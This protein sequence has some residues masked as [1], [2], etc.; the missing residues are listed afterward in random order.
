[1]GLV[2][3]PLVLLLFGFDCP[4]PYLTINELQGTNT[5]SPRVLGLSINNMVFKGHDGHS[6]DTILRKKELSLKNTISSS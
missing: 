6:I 5:S 3:G 1:M 2:Y 4:L